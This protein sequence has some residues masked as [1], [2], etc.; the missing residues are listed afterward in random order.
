MNS[1]LLLIRKADVRF[2]ETLAFL[3]IRLG[4]SSAAYTCI[5]D[6]MGIG[7][8]GPLYAMK[9]WANEFDAKNE[10][11][12]WNGDWVNELEEFFFKKL[13]EVRKRLNENNSL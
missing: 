10:N 6:Y 11:R 2:H 13:A 8:M 9:D 3:C 7:V 5:H 1:Q 4:L 12:Q